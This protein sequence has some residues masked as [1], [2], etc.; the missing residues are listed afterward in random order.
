VEVQD[1]FGLPLE[2]FVAERTALAK[3]L[4]SRGERDQAAQVEAL[5]KPTLAAWAVNQLVRTQGRDVKALFEAGDRARRSQAE[6]LAGRGAGAALREALDQ[7]RNAVSRLLGTARGLLSVEGDELSPAMLERVAETLHA[8]ALEDDA[9][10][11]VA[12]GCLQREL[13]HVGIGAAGLSGEPPPKSARTRAASA[14]PRADIKAL[15][16]AEGDARRAAE[17]ARK[18]AETAA[19]KRDTAAA[20]LKDAEQAAAEA[21]RRASEAE[22]AH[23]RAQRELGRVRRSA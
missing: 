11:Q 14:R 21:A 19:A 4:R 7:E 17:R 1:L 6:L 20:R 12:D 13:R 16:R 23:R 15:T 18:A 3:E 10:A 2:R 8:A 9:R 5:R 22:A